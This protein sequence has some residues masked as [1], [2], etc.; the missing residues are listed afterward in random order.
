MLI[1]VSFSGSCG[2][3]RDWPEV[4]NGILSASTSKDNQLTLSCNHGFEVDGATP[5]TCKP[6]V[7]AINYIHS[8]TCK[9]KC[10]PSKTGT[11]SVLGDITT[12]LFE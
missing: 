10:R 1:G 3:S 12:P 4:D 6:G 11:F 2:D 9:C 5:I 7:N 8:Q